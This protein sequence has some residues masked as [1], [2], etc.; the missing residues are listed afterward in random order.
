MQ[1]LLSLAVMVSFYMGGNH[2][3]I[4]IDTKISQGVQSSR[5]VEMDKIVMFITVT[6]YALCLLIPVLLYL[7]GKFRQQ[8]VF[9]FMAFQVILALALNAL[10]VGVVKYSINRPRPYTAVASVEQLA[11]AGSPSFP[12]GHTACAFVVAA[13]LCFMFKDRRL[14]FLVCLWAVSVAYSR[15]ALGVHYPSD[16]LGSVIIG[17]LCAFAGQA[18]FTYRW[19]RNSLLKP[20]S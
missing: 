16:V 8:K 6:T 12:S 19:N 5:V 14:R 2:T 15:L 18:A 4:A 3:Y 7:Y 1:I 13:T 17:T 11:S 9:K 20:F 10:L